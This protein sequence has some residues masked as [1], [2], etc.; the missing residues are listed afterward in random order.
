VVAIDSLPDDGRFAVRDVPA[1][2]RK[3]SIVA[4]GRAPYSAAIN[5]RANDTSKVLVP[6]ARVTTLSSVNVK[7]TAT[8]R[9]RSY[10]EHKLLGLGAF[11]D[12]SEIKNYPTR[13]SVMR[14]VPSTYIKHRNMNTLVFGPD[15][16]RPCQ[17]SKDEVDFRFDGH[18]TTAD[19]LSYLD[20]TTI[21]ALE[22]YRAAGQVPSDVMGTRRF[23]AVVIGG[24]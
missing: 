23:C 18:P 24:R 19:V 2:T 13:S 16:S 1:G 5:L 3:M 15:T 8:V 21:A 17:A 11:R 10:E 14:T 6:L 22:V 9:I 20:P 4:I 12:S 7:S